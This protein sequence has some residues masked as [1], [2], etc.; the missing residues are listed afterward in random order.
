[1]S[2]IRCK[3]DAQVSAKEVLLEVLW[4]NMMAN[5]SNKLTS[6]PITFVAFR[7]I[8]HLELVIE[9]AK[10]PF[11]CSKK[12]TNNTNLFLQ[13]CFFSPQEDVFK[14]ITE[15][16][17]KQGWFQIT[18]PAKNTAIHMI[19]KPFVALQEN[20]IADAEWTLWALKYLLCNKGLWRLLYLEDN[21]EITVAGYF[22]RHTDCWGDNLRV[23]EFLCSQGAPFVRHLNEPERRAGELRH[24][25]K[26]AIR[27]Y[28]IAY[29]AAFLHRRFPET[30]STETVMPLVVLFLCAEKVWLTGDE[31][32]RTSTFYLPE[33]TMSV[34]KR[35]TELACKRRM[36]QKRQHFNLNL[37]NSRWHFQSHILRFLNGLESDLL[38]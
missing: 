30:F 32:G 33:D 29:R 18:K 11:C 31:F 17:K 4:S 5:P 35:A 25:Q 24:Y 15:R 37:F 20:G 26:Q 14:H 38:Q 7:S 21:R 2:Q 27:V 19:I 10:D 36:L 12:S 8:K 28:R 13:A 34:Y 16:T 1:M 6:M 3:S 22:V 23:L 9:G